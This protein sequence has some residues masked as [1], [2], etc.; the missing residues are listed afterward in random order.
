MRHALMPHGTM[1]DGALKHF[2]SLFGLAEY[3]QYIPKQLPWYER[4][5]GAI[6]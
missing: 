6:L 2:L 4:G 5:P 3:T 1:Q